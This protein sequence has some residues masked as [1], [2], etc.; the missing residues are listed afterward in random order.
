MDTNYENKLRFFPLDRDLSNGKLYPPFGHG[1]VSTTGIAASDRK[2]GCTDRAECTG[3]SSEC[4]ECT[5]L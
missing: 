2:A 1:V 3:G 5:G 4:A